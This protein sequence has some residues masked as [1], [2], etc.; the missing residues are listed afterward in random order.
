MTEWAEVPHEAEAGRDGGIDNHFGDQHRR[1]MT[2]DD[3]IELGDVIDYQ[4]FRTASRT[5]LD[6]RRDAVAAFQT[7]AQT[8]AEAEAHY[9]RTKAQRFVALKSNIT[10]TE[11]EMRI[12]GDEEVAVAMIERDVQREALKARRADIE[13]VDEALATLRRLAEWS[14]T[15]RGAA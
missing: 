2:I 15:E 14:Q 3:P 10:V 8:T 5:L 12:K 9:Q 1:P 13:G 11:A 6:R 7:Q 4:D